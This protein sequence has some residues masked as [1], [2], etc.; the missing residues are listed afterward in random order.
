[1]RE[2][3]EYLLQHFGRPAFRE[4]AGTLARKIEVYASR[5]G[6]EFIKSRPAG[7]A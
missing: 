1:V 7:G 4:G 5:H 3:A 2:T 6:D